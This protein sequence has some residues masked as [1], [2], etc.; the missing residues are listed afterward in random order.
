MKMNVS[1]K[2][3]IQLQ[4]RQ[5]LRRR[6]LRGVGHARILRNIPIILVDNKSRNTVCWPDIF[7]SNQPVIIRGL[8]STWPAISND[9]RKWSNL[10]QLKRRID[11]DTVVP[12]E[13][14][15]HYMDKN[16][17]KVS[18]GLGSLLDYFRLGK[19]SMAS[20]PRVYWAQSELKDVPEML[21]DVMVPEMC[22]TTGKGHLY[23]TNVWFGGAL[24]SVSPCHFDPFYNLLCQVVG[25]KEVTVF[26]PEF[27][28][29]YLYPAE[30]TVQKN[31]SL[32]DME[33]PDFT[34]HPL[35]A[36][37]LKIVNAGIEPKEVSNEDGEGKV[38]EITAPHGSTPTILTPLS[39]EFVGATGM[40]E[41]GDA[42]YIPYKW[43]HYCS[44]SSVSA[45]VNFW[46]L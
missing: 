22:T 23:R 21:A 7:K 9:T 20:I 43:W 13:M 10:V 19:E 29:Q 41:P 34:T 5:L 30:G 6:N 35:Y 40:L 33:N 44:T 27:G 3:P 1:I 45:S 8:V 38:I 15:N 26:A 2:G 36:E 32:V 12:V 28:H 18:V 4:C 31:T 46:W 14:G 16:L 24:G 42:V 25:T 17:K 39:H 11:E 37:A